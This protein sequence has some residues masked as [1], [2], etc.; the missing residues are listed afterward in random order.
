MDIRRITHTLKRYGMVINHKK[1]LK[2]MKKMGIQCKKRRKFTVTTNSSHKFRTYP[3][4]AKNIEICRVNQLWCAD[5][6]Y[7]RILTTFVYLAAIIDAYR[8]KIVGYAIGRTLTTE[9]T[10]EALKMAIRGRNT[11]DLI[12][13]SDRRIQYASY[14]YIKLLRS[15]GI[16]ISMSAKGSPYDN[17]TIESFFKTLKSEEVYLWEYETYRDVIERIPYFIED[18]YN[19]KRLHSSLSC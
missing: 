9:L 12:H 10:L 14:Y 18:V 4:L 13:H 15:N 6:T 17:A 19:K 7:I 8:G 2:L 1:I 3:N 16:K 5:I 11:D